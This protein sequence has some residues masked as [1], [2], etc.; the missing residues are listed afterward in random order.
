MHSVAEINVYRAAVAPEYPGALC[1]ALV[2]MAGGI[3]NAAVR[4]CF[5]YPE[6][7]FAS[8]G[9]RAYKELSDKPGCPCYEEI[10]SD[11]IERDRN[12]MNRKTA[13]L[14]QAEDAVLVDTT[15]LGLE[16]SAE[17]ISRIISEKLS[18]GGE[19]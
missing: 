13:P 12:D 5:G 17:E 16:E 4:L 1:F 11:I 14:R 9:K 18:S 8:V 6:A 10:L 19:M 15:N 3:L 2:S 7:L